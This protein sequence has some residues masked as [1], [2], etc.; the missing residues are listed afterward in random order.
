MTFIIRILK[1]IYDFHIV[2]YLRGPDK[3][4]GKKYLEI[5]LGKNYLERIK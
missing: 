5:I 2:L 4:L 3:L 1:D